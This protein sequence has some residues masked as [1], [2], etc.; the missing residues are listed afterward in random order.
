MK[1]DKTIVFLSALLIMATS[2][3]SDDSTWSTYLKQA[4]QGTA[5]ILPD[6]SYAGYHHGEKGIPDVEGRVFNV[7]DYGAVPDDDISDKEAIRRTIRAV[8]DN[9]SGIVFFPEGRFHVNTESDDDK[10]IYINTGNIVFRGSGSE[11]GGS[12]IFMERHLP[13]DDPEKLWTT[14]HLFQFVCKG[15]EK[16]ITRVVED[17]G[18]NTR[19]LLVENADKIKSGDWIILRVS[20]NSPELIAREMH[21]IPCDENWT[22]IL[23]DGVYINEYH[24]VAE[25]NGN[26][27]LLKEP[28]LHELEHKYGCQI[29][30]YPHHEEVGVENLAFTG[31]WHD[32]F[33]HHKN[34]LHDGGYSMLKLQRVTN[35]WVRNCRFTDVNRA[36]SIALSSNVSVI[37]CSVTGT[38]GHNSISANGSTRVLIGKVWDSSS[39]WH[40]PGVAGPSIGTVLWRVKYNENTCFESHA[41]QPRATLFDC[42]EGGFMLGRAGGARKNLPNHLEYLVLWNYKELDE[43]DTDFEFWSSKTWYWKII[44]PYIIGFHGSG[45]TFLESQ[46]SVLESPGTPVLPESL[47]EAQLRLRLGHLPA[48]IEALIIQ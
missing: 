18:F 43:P 21:G 26:T 11:E 36:A 8:E 13:P 42:I 29:L 7:M 37:N 19:S 10:P 12:E 30:S 35:S 17:A 5:T 34:C 46:V 2:C 44:P 31:N 39:Q 20:N 3:V 6:F 14:P 47:Y 23:E 48:W 28:I 33:V 15:R 25:V 9:G 32:E 22:T 1:P 16:F 4:N 45:T 27:V 38:P 41:S 24:Q 40:A